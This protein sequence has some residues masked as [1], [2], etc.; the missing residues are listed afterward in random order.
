MSEPSTPTEE[1]GEALSRLA[2][3]GEKKKR[4]GGGWGPFVLILVLLIPLTAVGW[5][6]WQ[7][8]DMQKALAA[9]REENVVL[10][11]QSA[12]DTDQIARAQAELEAA[13]QQ[14][15]Q[16]Q[17]QLA[18]VQQ[19]VQDA[20]QREQAEDSAAEQSLEQELTASQAALA[21]QAQQLAAQSEKITALETELTEMRSHLDTL[22]AGNSPLAE[23]EV[24]LRFAQQRLAL[25]RDTATAL[26]LFED[27]D[28]LLRDMDDPA[29][30]TVRESLAREIAALQAVPTVDV[31]GL[32]ARLSAEAARVESLAVVSNATV[33]DFAVTPVLSEPPE[34]SDWWTRAKRSLGEYFVVTHSTGQAVPQLSANDQ[35]QQRAL[36]QVHIE[37][38]KLALL[39]NDQPLYEA[40]L[41]D[42]LVAARRWLRSD[43]TSFDEFVAA[44]QTLRDT[45]IVVDIPASDATLKELQRLSGR[46][47]SSAP[48][49]TAIANG[50][51]P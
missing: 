31:S 26:E 37:Q 28:A 32:F 49:A 14:F 44:L 18:D 27:A 41:D 15:Q 20:Q 21:T 48:A 19:Q 4:S 42:A 11:Q 34:N 2:T 43:D 17:Q 29:L 25:A 16:A 38:A 3:H 24:L 45:P 23:A 8:R 22:G 36:V 50:A 6:A 1:T 35:F 13:Q 47:A 5:L 7:Q 33:Q 9:L 46:N 40:A 51:V 10:Q 30:A 39:R 12:A